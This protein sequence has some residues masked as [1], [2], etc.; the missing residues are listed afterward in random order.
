MHEF[1]DSKGRPWHI[2]INLDTIELVKADCGVNVL[3]IADPDSDLLKELAVFP[4]LVGKILF[5]ALSD[6]AKT[7]EVDAKEFRRS[8]GGEAFQKGYDALLDEVILFSPPRRRQILQAV[9]DKNRE[10][11]E[12]GISLA[13][14][15]LSDP[16]LKTQAME[17]MDRQL[18]QR[19]KEA[20]E[21]LSGGIASHSV[22]GSSSGAMPPRDFSTLPTQDRTHG[23]NSSDSPTEP[24]SPTAT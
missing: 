15:K 22:N 7:K 21:N 6:E 10:V 20:I 13:M 12:E 18:S 8:I 2:E 11:E 23:G 24:T 1:L 16:N 19:I 17:A 9:R 3:D 14:Q 5:A 4:M